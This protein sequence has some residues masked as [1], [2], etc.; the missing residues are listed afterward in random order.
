MSTGLRT[1][2]RRLLPAAAFAIG[3]MLSCGGAPRQA[4]AL[5]SAN[6]FE[7][8]VAA[9]RAAESGDAEAVAT[10]VDLLEDRDPAVRM[11]A[12]LALRRLTAKDYGYRYYAELGERVRAV[13][14]WR[15]ALRQGDVTVRPQFAAQAPVDREPPTDE[16]EGSR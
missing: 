11:Y 15:E 6:P 5:R 13:A 1:T 9:V 12:I 2:H 16:A 7:R 14:R 8:S 3:S 4:E 10:L